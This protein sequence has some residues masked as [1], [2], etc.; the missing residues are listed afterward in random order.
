MRAALLA[1]VAALALVGCTVTVR[2][3]PATT[4]TPTTLESAAP[5]D[6]ATGGRLV[7][8]VRA[9][10]PAAFTGYTDG[11]LTG[12]AASTCRAL[13]AGAPLGEVTAA[14]LDGG[15]AARPAGYLLGASIAVVCPGH[16][17]LIPPAPSPA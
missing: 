6:P 16:L 17:D 1:V 8:L 12:I 2:S 14:M 3:T 7:D 15:L 5:V 11:D 9:A 10:Y 4:S 13:D